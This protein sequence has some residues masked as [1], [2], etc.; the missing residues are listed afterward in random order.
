MSV[1]RGVVAG[2]PAKGLVRRRR[3]RPGPAARGPRHRSR[4]P[5]GPLRR[6]DPRRL[7]RRYPSRIHLGGR[8]TQCGPRSF[9][10][11]SRRKCGTWPPAGPRGL[12]NQ[13]SI[14]ESPEFQVRDPH[15]LERHQLNGTL[16][17]T[18]ITAANVQ[19]APDRMFGTRSRACR[20]G[21]IMN[22]RDG[23]RC[24]YATTPNAFDDDA[25]AI[26][27]TF[28][29]FAAVG[30]AAT[31]ADAQHDARGRRAARPAASAAREAARRQGLRPQERPRRSPRPS[32][33]GLR[34]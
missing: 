30:R 1:A 5:R 17:F 2:G 32:L 23:H 16:G 11:S 22:R 13:E 7:V 4:Q 33:A 3:R 14:E 19:V 10:N 26:A 9:P 6:S 24:I 18:E 27:Q 8:A 29:G 31:A 20:C 21:A 34:S 28:A 15:T 12:R 25:I